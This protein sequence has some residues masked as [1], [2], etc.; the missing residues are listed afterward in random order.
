LVFFVLYVPY[1]ST[2]FCVET[3]QI[4][5]LH[6]NSVPDNGNLTAIKAAE[7]LKDEA[8]VEVPNTI[9]RSPTL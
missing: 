8:L 1:I 7:H 2:Y 5:L 6:Q 3:D 9:G 4:K